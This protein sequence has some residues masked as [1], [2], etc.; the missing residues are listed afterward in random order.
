MSSVA[1]TCTMS[2]GRTIIT[3]YSGILSDTATPQKYDI[4]RVFFIYKSAWYNALKGLPFF[5][6]MWTI[7]SLLLKQRSTSV[8]AIVRYK[9]Q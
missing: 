9:T 6:E 4:I 2:L 8:S 5:Y 3:V 7:N 1:E